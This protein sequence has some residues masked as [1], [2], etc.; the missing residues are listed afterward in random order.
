MESVG[1]GED[2]SEGERTRISLGVN[3]VHR[4]V[5]LE[6]YLRDQVVW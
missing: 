4:E 6:E 2:W 3:D 1:G 5:Q